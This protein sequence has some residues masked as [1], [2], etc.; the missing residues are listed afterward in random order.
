MHVLAG[1]NEDRCIYFF[2]VKLNFVLAQFKEVL[3]WKRNTEH[4]LVPKQNDT[5][6][7]DGQAGLG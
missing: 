5:K 6:E 3:V 2:G 4:L 7:V 1:V